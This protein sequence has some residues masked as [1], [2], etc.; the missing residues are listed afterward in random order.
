MSELLQLQQ[1][2]AKDVAQ[3]IA[4]A[5]VLGYGVTLG[6]AWRTPEQAQWNAEHG[7]GVAH[8][9]HEERLAID[10]NLF[11]DGQYLTEAEAYRALGEWWKK[12]SPAHCWGGDFHG[13]VDLDHYSITPDGVHK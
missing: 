11:K 12:L 7:K 13:L 3:L 8:S 1:Q 2:F 6:E 9:L 4:Y 5:A 10:L